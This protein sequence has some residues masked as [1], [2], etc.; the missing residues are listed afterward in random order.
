MKRK[1]GPNR[2]QFEYNKS[3]WPLWTKY[4]FILYKFDDLQSRTGNLKSEENLKKKFKRDSVT[5][6]K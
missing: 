2:Q 1:K 3:A 6:K 5:T 4:P